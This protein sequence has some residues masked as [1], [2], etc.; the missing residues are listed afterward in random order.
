MVCVAGAIAGIADQPIQGVLSS[1][2]LSDNSLASGFVT[3]VGKGLVGVVT[4]PIGGAAEF[5]SQ[6]GQGEYLLFEASVVNNRL[7]YFAVDKPF[8]PTIWKYHS[9]LLLH[10]Y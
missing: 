9:Y 4:K 6:T 5:L 10:L 1:Q 2:L 8:I 3:G 7:L